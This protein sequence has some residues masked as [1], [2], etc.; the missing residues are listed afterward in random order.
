MVSDHPLPSYFHLKIHNIETQKKRPKAMDW[1]PSR[2]STFVNSKASL[3]PVLRG[4][5]PSNTTTL[6]SRAVF[7]PFIYF[8]RSLSVLHST[9][10][11]EARLL[12]VA[13]V[14]HILSFIVLFL[15][16]TF[17][18]AAKSIHRPRFLT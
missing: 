2:K 3:T 4:T 18:L 12:L 10:A 6:G 13:G 8:V 14:F 9:S 5:P 17:V 1:P 16:F 15:P 7:P 11:S